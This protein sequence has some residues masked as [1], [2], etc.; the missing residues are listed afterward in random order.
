MKAELKQA[1]VTLCRT[2]LWA[3]SKNLSVFFEY[4]GHVDVVSVRVYV[5]GWVKG[6]N[7]DHELSRHLSWCQDA[8]GNINKME[9][10]VHDLGMEHN[11]GE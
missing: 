3:N 8:L 2:C 10:L 5:G 1:I 9:Q 7:P 6:K 4:S 11:G